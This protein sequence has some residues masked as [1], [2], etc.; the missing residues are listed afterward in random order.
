MF[1]FCDLFLF[2]VWLGSL[3]AWFWLLLVSCF[4]VAWFCPAAHND[5]DGW[6]MD[7]HV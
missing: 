2:V 4:S 7:D 5:G 1:L 6:V 3:V